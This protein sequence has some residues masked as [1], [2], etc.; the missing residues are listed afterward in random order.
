MIDSTTGWYQITQYDNKTVT[1]I[2][3]LVENPWLKKYPRPIEITYVQGSFFIGHE[4]RKSP[5][6]K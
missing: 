1:S 6:D 2:E 3:N 4:F 5:I